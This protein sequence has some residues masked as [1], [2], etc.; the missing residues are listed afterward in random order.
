MDRYL[1]PMM[2]C[3][4]IFMEILGCFIIAKICDIEV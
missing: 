2:L 3:T 1:G 4:G